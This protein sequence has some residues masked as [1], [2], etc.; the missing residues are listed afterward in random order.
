MRREDLKG[1]LTASWAVIVFGFGD[2]EAG[3]AVD[4]M[5]AGALR[6]FES[7]FEA[8]C[9]LEVVVEEGVLRDFDGA[10]LLHC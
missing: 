1:D 3:F 8:D 4:I 5:A 7:G 9:A 2:C 10:L 6:G